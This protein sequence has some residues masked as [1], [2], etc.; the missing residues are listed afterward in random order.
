MERVT[1]QYVSAV[2]S[3]SASNSVPILE[4]KLEFVP[5]PRH[6]LFNKMKAPLEHP[7]VYNNGYTI[8]SPVIY[9]NASDTRNNNLPNTSLFTHLRQMRSSCVK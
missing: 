4:C 1:V 7:W 2:A 6:S 5:L 3:T 9:L 8:A